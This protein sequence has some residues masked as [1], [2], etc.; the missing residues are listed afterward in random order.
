VAEWLFEKLG[1]GEPGWYIGFGLVC[2]GSV[3]GFTEAA[4]SGIEALCKVV[5]GK[6]K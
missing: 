6:Q 1:S 5:K 4:I 3:Y 2:I